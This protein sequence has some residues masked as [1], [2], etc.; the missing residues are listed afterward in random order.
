MIVNAGLNPGKIFDQR[1][2]LGDTQNA[3]C[4]AV[5]FI[6][7]PDFILNGPELLRYTNY[8]IQEIA[9]GSERR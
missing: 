3:I 1:R 7:R 5:T 2:D 8:V 4:P 9:P 6:S